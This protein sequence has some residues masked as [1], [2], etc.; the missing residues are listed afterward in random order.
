MITKSTLLALH[1]R[2]QAQCMDVAVY[3]Y[4][5]LYLYKQTTGGCCSDCPSLNMTAFCCM[6]LILVPQ[7]ALGRLMHSVRGLMNS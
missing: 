6:C 7:I 1:G 2:Y 4:L 3:L 5:Y